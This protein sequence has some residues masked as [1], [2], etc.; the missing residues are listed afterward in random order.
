MALCILHAGS[1]R[2]YTRFRHSRRYLSSRVWSYQDDK[3]AGLPGLFPWKDAPGCR[4]D[5]IGM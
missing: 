1:H 5:M 3:K 4:Y 2:I